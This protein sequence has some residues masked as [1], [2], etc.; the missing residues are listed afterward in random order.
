MQMQI[1]LFIKGQIEFLLGKNRGSASPSL[2]GDSLPIADFNTEHQ[3]EPKETFSTHLGILLKRRNRHVIIL[4]F[5]R[6][7]R[8]APLAR[9]QKNTKHFRIF[10]LK[11]SS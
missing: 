3:N 2:A 5:K 9:P 6:S 1:R 11:I 4:A 8:L 7:W 10:F